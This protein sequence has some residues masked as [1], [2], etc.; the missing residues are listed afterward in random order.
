MFGQH[1]HN[2][3]KTL[4]TTITKAVIQGKQ[5]FHVFK[6]AEGMPKIVSCSLEEYNAL[7]LV[8]ALKPQ[9]EGHEWM[10][11][12]DYPLIDSASGFLEANQYIE[13]GTDSVLIKL[14]S[15][16]PLEAV[17]I[18]KDRVVNDALTQS[19]IDEI[20]ELYGDKLE[21]I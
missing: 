6:D 21:I 5:Y 11:S 8:D 20:Q 13:V 7:G 18:K 2:M 12:C 14:D 15:A 3:S 1:T 16:D 4:S 17:E 19:G 10:Y 9:L